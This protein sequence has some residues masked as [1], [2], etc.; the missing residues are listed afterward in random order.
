MTGNIWYQ[1]DPFCWIQ[2][3]TSLLGLAVK[4]AQLDIHPQEHPSPSAHSDP[5]S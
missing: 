1:L 4:V 2:V 5:P 3:R